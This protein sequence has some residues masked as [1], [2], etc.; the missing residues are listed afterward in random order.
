MGK[1]STEMAEEGSS[2]VKDVAGNGPADESTPLP[3]HKTLN[4]KEMF[5]ER[6][7]MQAE[8]KDA[9]QRENEARKVEV[10]PVTNDK[11]SK[12]A[13]AQDQVDDVLDHSST[14]IPAKTATNVTSLETFTS[15][16]ATLTPLQS[17]MRQKLISSRFRHLNETLYTTPSTSS[18]ELFTQNPTFFSEY[19]EGFRRQ[20]TAWPENPVDGFI[21]W[22]CDRGKDGA[23]IAEQGSQKSRFR[24]SQNLKKENEK[25]IVQE[26]Q[27]AGSDGK[28]IDPLPRNFRTGVCTIADLGCGDAQLAQHLSKPTPSPATKVLKLRV[29]SFDLAAPSSLITVSDIRSLPLTDSSVDLAIFCLALMG[30]NWIDFIEEAYRVLRWKG[31]CWIAEVCSRFASTKSRRVEHSVGKRSKAADIRANKSKKSIH[32]DEDE[33]EPVLGMIGEVTT[34]PTTTTP[35]ASTDV[36]DFIA[37]MCRRGFVL[38]GEPELGNKMFVRMRFIKAMAPTRGKGKATAQAGLEKKKR[39]I[40]KEEDE[41]VSMEEEAKVL[42]PCVYKTR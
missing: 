20:V 26:T 18:Y 9:R 4:G 39:F 38:Q 34:T 37:V 28:G 23:E 5:E 31:E 7:K 1:K 3:K 16:D 25:R 33:A 22:I 29:C 6:R 40:D 11:I 36:S 27:Q 42:R 15:T 19:H 24:K 32:R 10:E 35:Q 13:K 21:R 17:S 12:A 14:T 8:K 2:P 30:T 41:E